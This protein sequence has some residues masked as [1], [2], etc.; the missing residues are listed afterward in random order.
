MKKIYFA[1][2]VLW[3]AWGPAGCPEILRA[4]QVH[5]TH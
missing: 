2:A 4:E 3:M 5:A 1:F